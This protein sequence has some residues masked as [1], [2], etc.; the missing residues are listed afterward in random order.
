M[1]ICSFCQGVGDGFVDSEGW[2]W[3]VCPKCKGDGIIFDKE[4]KIVKEDNKER[5]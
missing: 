1:K 4:T 2:R 5:R 3:R